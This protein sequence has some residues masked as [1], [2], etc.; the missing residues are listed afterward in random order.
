MCILIREYIQNNR[1]KL[2]IIERNTP[3]NEHYYTEEIY[4]KKLLAKI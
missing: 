1:I 2:D 3:G 4:F